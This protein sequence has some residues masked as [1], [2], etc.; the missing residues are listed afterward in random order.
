MRI[1]KRIKLPGWIVLILFSLFLIGTIYHFT[2]T[3]TETYTENTD[4]LYKTTNNQKIVQEEM[5]DTEEAAIQKKETEDITRV[6]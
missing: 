2:N 4:S 3:R 5:Q 6:D 1:I